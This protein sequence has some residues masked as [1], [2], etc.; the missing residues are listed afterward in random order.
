VNLSVAIA[1]TAGAFRLD[2]ETEIGSGLTALVGPSGAGK[3][4][5]L[6]VIAGLT[7]PARAVITMDQATIVNTT[8]GAWVP[9]HR[10]RI[11]YVF[12]EPR[13]FP[14]LSVK[15]NLLYGQWCRRR[16]A[17]GLPAAEVTALLNLEPLLARYPLRLSGGERQ[18]VA[19]GRALLSKPALLLMDEPLASVD[20]AHRL[21]ILPY[22][23]RV[24]SEHAIPTVY[25]TH[26]MAEVTG[27]DR[28]I[29][30]EHGRVRV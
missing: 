4:T 29:E 26:T 18:R 27:A 12:Q 6:K 9:A 5:L 13:L 30:L 11:G 7:R 22:L 19:L 16:V 28:I 24:R 3:T 2:V 15:Q 23:H 10:R 21:E 1:F 20:Q 25:V 17:G 14:H 8:T